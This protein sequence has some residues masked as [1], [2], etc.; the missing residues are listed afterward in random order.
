MLTVDDWNE[1]VCLSGGACSTIGVCNI[2]LVTSIATD[3]QVK[4]GDILAVTAG[5]G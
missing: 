3:T 5:F 4:H 2:R 1:Q